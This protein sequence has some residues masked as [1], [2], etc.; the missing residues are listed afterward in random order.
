MITESQKKNAERA[1]DLLY[2]RRIKPASI[3]ALAHVSPVTVRCVL[4]GH[5]TSR[6][7]QEAVAVLLGKPYETLWGAD[8]HESIVSDRKSAVND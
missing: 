5:G 8:K 7:I 4:N 3:A 1:K 6:P 2:L